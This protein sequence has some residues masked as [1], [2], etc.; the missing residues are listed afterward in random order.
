MN[1]NDW[2]N[3]FLIGAPKCGTTSMF[4]WLANHPEICASQPKET[5]F[6]CDQELKYLNIKPNHHHN[7]K[8]DYLSYFKDINKLTKIKMEGSSHY[9]YS[10]PALKFLSKISPKPKIIVQLR[11]PS[12]RI[13][14][15]FN[16]INQQAIYPIKISFSNYVDAILKKQTKTNYKFTNEPWPQYLLENLLSYSNYQHH[17]HAWMNMFTKENIKI[18]ILENLIQ[19]KSNTLKD[20]AKWINIDSKFYE[21]FKFE[22]KNVSKTRISQEIKRY[23]NPFKKFIPKSTI[24]FSERVLDMMLTPFKVKQSEA[25]KIAL[26]KLADYFETPNQKLKNEFGLNIANWNH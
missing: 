6:F 20:I 17:L 24:Y 14:S 7:D 8:A 3:L 15:H 23:F 21:H 18:L 9:L 4:N 22:S 11:D 2:P 1:K 26:S 5:W 16:Y 25:D 10:K 12:T 13:W 19:Q